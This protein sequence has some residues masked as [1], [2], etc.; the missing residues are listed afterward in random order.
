MDRPGTHPI[1]SV[2]VHPNHRSSHLLKYEL[3]PERNEMENAGIGAG[4]GALGFWLFIAAVVVGGMWYAIREREAE[5]ETLRRL[6]E[7]GKPLDERLLDKLVRANKRP[8]RD[9]K[10][11]GIIMAFIAP[12]LAVM[13]FFI[14]QIEEQALFPILGAAFLSGFISAGLLVTSKVME[15]TYG[16]EEKPL[17]DEQRM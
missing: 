1:L 12:G 5:H 10:L 4:L 9:L 8:D 14:A 17:S 16:D 6:I 11:A 2:R 7:S 15:R 3:Q 13:A